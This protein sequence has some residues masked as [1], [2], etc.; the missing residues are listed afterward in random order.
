MCIF[1]QDGA[2]AQIVSLSQQVTQLNDSHDKSATQ[3]LLLQTSLTQLEQGK[4]T[5]G[6][7][8][9]TVNITY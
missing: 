2:K 6:S 7:C 8:K 3:V 4:K 9:H 5:S 1:P